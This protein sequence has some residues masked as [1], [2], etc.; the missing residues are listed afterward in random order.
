VHQCKG[1]KNEYLRHVVEDKVS[2]TSREIDEKGKC[3]ADFMRAMYRGVQKA[4]M[5]HEA[6]LQAGVDHVQRLGY[7]LTANIDSEWAVGYVP[8][9]DWLLIVQIGTPRSLEKSFL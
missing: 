8:Y 4:R 9:E 2:A 1:L 7:F 3:A 6:E 5:T